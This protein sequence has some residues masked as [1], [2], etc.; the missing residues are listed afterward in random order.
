M[1]RSA[2][3]GR[4]PQWR[5]GQ[6]NQ[7][8]GPAQQGE[9]DGRKSKGEGQ[10]GDGDPQAT[11]RRIANDLAERQRDLAEAL[12]QQQLQPLPGEGMPEGDA[13]LDALERAQRAMED[14]AEALEQ[15]R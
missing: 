12:R 15:G 11:R 13:A 5:A 4:V 14:A 3:A 2:S 1:T 7:P 8:P 9:T 6:G 10:Q